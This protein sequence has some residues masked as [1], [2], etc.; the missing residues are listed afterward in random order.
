MFGGAAWILVLSTL[1][2]VYQLSLPGWVK[3]RGMGFY[4]IAFQGGM[5]VGSAVVGVT[6][7]HAGLSRT[8]FVT[9]VGLF[10]VPL[11]A[12]R[13]KFQT[14]APEDLLPA[15]DWPQPHVF[16]DEDDDAF[17]G[18][19]M[20]NVEYRP[21][22]EP[23]TSSSPSSTTRATVVAVPGLSRGGSGAMPRTRT[24][25]SSSSWWRRGR[26]TCASTNGSANAIR[27]ASTASSDLTDPEHPP[28]ATHWI[29]PERRSHR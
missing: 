16:D 27:P 29:A 23:K 13:Y 26:N 1:G 19:V 11:A 25:S 10:S 15:G 24:A 21:V 4:L 7:Q 22:P 3:T 2:S 20:V 6:A 17:V 12:L 28:I 8:L 5:A 9:G 18:P 14:I